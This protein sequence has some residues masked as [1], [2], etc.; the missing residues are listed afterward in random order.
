MSPQTGQLGFPRGYAQYTNLAAAISLDDAPATGVKQSAAGSFSR[1]LLQAENADIRWR[2]DGTNPTATVGFI[3]PAGES[4]VYEGDI[5]DLK[6]IQV[7]AG[8]ILN[9]GYYG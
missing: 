9:V 5:A 3:L 2:D 7:S 8:A 4:Y 6:L 1:A